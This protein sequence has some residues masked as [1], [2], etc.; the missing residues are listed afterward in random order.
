MKAGCGRRWRFEMR[1]ALV[2]ALVLGAAAVFSG[3]PAVAGE[4]AFCMKGQDIDS[5]HG[6]CSYDTYQQCLASAPAAGITATPTRSTP[7]SRAG[8]AAPAPSPSASLLSAARA[9]AA[10]RHGLVVQRSSTIWPFSSETRRSMRAASSMLGSRSASPPRRPDQFASAP[11][12]RDRRC[13]D[14]GCRRLVGEQHPRAHWPPRARSPPCCSPP[15]SSAGRCA[16]R[17]PSPR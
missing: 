14:R 3:T 10:P 8:C 2:A 16:T 1:S 4:R 12:R 15:D 17:S 6:D 13:A 11:E 9:A 5:A 7:A